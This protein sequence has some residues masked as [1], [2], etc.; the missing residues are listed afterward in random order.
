MDVKVIGLTAV[1]SATSAP[2]TVSVTPLSNLTV[3][4]A[5]MVRVAEFETDIE[6]FMIYGL[7]DVVHVV[8][9]V[10]SDAGQATK[11]DKI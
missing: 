9:E 1:P 2:F 4:P 8:F 3:T 5:C 7:P 11:E 10:I 6:F